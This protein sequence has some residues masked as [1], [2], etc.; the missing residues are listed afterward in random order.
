MKSK[1]AKLVFA[2]DASGSMEDIQDAMD[3]QINGMVKDQQG[4]PGDCTCSIYQFDSGFD[5][6]LRL[7]NEVKSVNIHDVP[8]FKLSPGGGTP[9]IDA[10]CHIIDDVGKELAGTK[11]ADRPER[12]IFVIVTDG[13]ENSSREFN[14]AQLKSRIEEQTNKYSWTFMFLG[15]DQNAVK[16]AES[17]GM[18]GN[19][20]MTFGKTR[21]GVSKMSNLTSDKIK[22]MRAMTPGEY[23]LNASTGDITAYTE[24]ERADQVVEGVKV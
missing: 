24:A 19:H 13:E 17:Y 16:E 2:I 7:V 10:L 12:V 5:R 9:L 15:A 4:E 8:K 22:L 6:R 3:E 21:G 20:S 18:S 14:R 11:E 23:V 1:S